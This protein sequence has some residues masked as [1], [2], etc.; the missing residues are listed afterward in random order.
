MISDPP[1]DEEWSAPED[2]FNYA[3]D[4]VRFIREEFGDYFVIC[5]A[6]NLCSNFTLENQTSAIKNH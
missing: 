5:V 3:T 6:G 2:G 1:A 4:L